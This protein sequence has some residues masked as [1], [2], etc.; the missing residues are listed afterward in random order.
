MTSVLVIITTFCIAQ[1]LHECCTWVQLPMFE[2]CEGSVR[3]SGFKLLEEA[4]PQNERFKLTDPCVTKTL[5]FETG[6][7]KLKCVKSR[8]MGLVQ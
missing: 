7:A 2:M 1:K 8:V 6:L 4:N 5:V 3:A